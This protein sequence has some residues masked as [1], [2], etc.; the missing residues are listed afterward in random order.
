MPNIRYLFLQCMLII[1]P[2]SNLTSFRGKIKYSNEH[3][4]TWARK[5]YPR[6]SITRRKER[7]HG[8]WS[9]N[10]AGSSEK[11]SKMRKKKAR[12]REKERERK[13]EALKRPCYPSCPYASSTFPPPH[14]P[15]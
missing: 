12:R 9:Y 3:E 15:P 6:N 7:R 11:A 13:M 2:V 5:N 1:L 4:I 10:T 8:S 14:A